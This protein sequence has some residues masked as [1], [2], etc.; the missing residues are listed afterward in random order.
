MSIQLDRNKPNSWFLR[1]MYK[2][3]KFTPLT[4]EA[5]FKMFLNLEW[6]FDRI[7]HEYSFRNYEPDEHPVR[8]FTKRHLLEWI[9]P[10]HSVLDLGC[11]TGEMSFWAS[12]KAKKVTGIDYNPV[13]IDFAK[14]NYKRENLYFHCIEA[15]E[16]LSNTEEKFDVLILENVLEHL[17]NP[18]EFI[19]KFSK[20]FEY[21][22]IELPDFDKNY[23]NH[24]RKDLN[25]SLIYTDT[26]HV[27]EFDRFDM[28]RLIEDNNLSVIHAH[29]IHGFQKLWCKVNGEK[30]N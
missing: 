28:V 14:E 17:D 12:E 13:H 26:D 27:S 15:H 20:F 29:Y 30:V 21:V 6:F 23:L 9:E 1:I 7:A 25:L 22:Y 3:A 11:A 16:Y 18:S 2:L 10:E 8:I 4:N 5:K 19:G 24:Y